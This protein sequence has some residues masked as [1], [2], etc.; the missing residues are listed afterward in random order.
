MLVLTA[1]TT[2]VFAAPKAES[3]STPREASQSDPG[4]P[5][6]GAGAKV[7]SAV[8]VK[9][10]SS[11]SVPKGRQVALKMAEGLRF[12]PP[13][14]EAKP[15]EFLSVQVENVDPSHLAHNLVIVKPGQVQE[16]VQLA[17]GMGESG[18]AK[19]FVPTH[20][21][22][23][24][25][26]STVVDPEKKLQV[27][28]KVPDEPG[29]Y[30]YV[31]TVPGH[32][33]V[34]FGAMYVGVPMPPL[35]KDPN[36]PQMNLEKG[37][38]GGGRRPF[39]Q[40]MFLPNSGPAAIAVA[41]TGNQNFC[42]DAGSCY[43]RYAWE[44]PFLDAGAHWRG[45]GNALAELG[46]SPWW[47]ADG[48]PIRLGDGKAGDSKGGVGK[49]GVQKVKFLGYKLL[50]GVPEFRYEVGKQEVFE[51]VTSHENGLVFHFRLP[52]VDQKVAF[53]GGSGG[54][55]WV[56]VGGEFVNGVLELPADKASEFSVR[57][58][59]SDVN[60]GGEKKSPTGAT[61]HPHKTTVTP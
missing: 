23:L 26:S 31:C 45:N 16:I 18:P 2:P 12:D 33:M 46:D 8:S 48:F 57:I 3:L 32:G 22:I 7:G 52:G 41:L 10:A 51:T 40:R 1:L 5:S 36:I 59:A 42:F 53:V 43:V 29:V 13:R 44:G 21:A 25:A 54:G 28:F 39:V 58:E 17:M 37:L 14:F 56:G 35:A 49:G 34:M 24:A 47:R 19:A 6:G 11:A 20:P 15:G 50:D 27:K 61:E 30:G 38:A 55:K 60:A 9:P 4:A